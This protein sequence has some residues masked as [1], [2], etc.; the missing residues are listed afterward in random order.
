MWIERGGPFILAECKL[1]EAPDESATR[2]FGAFAALY[3]KPSVASAMVVCRASRAYRLKSPFGAR[4]VG[5]R[6]ALRAIG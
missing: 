1:A 6:E 5:M 2:G 4:A 3:G